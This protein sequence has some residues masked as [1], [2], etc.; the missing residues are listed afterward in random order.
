MCVRKR[1]DSCV[2]ATGIQSTI[3]WLKHRN[4]MLIF[5]QSAHFTVSTCHL[6]KKPKSRL[7]A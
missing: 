1:G 3:Q 6:K 2:V 4:G 5:T 7:P